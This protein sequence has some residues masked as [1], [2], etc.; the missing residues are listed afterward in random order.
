M[1]PSILLAIIC[2]WIT[3][4]AQHGTPYDPANDPGEATSPWSPP[5]YPG[6]DLTSPRPMP[7]NGYPTTS[8]GY[9]RFE[10]IVES[11]VERSMSF[12]GATLVDDNLVVLFERSPSQNIYFWEVYSLTSNSKFEVICSI[13]RPLASSG[14]FMNMT[15]AGDLVYILNSDY[16]SGTNVYQLDL[17]DCSTSFLQNLSSATS[18]VR[19]PFGI[20][21]SKYYVTISGQL[22]TFDF[23][24]RLIQPFHYAKESL[25]SVKPN[26]T[27][28]SFTVSETGALWY[29]DSIA[30]LWQGRTDGSW[31]GWV[32]LPYS[33]Y[34]DLMNTQSLVSNRDGRLSIITFDPTATERI[35]RVY[36]IDASNF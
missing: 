17:S 28:P 31:D 21:G 26:P 33:T 18:Y 36:K 23:K 27:Y 29:T 12:V 9:V 34:R 2:I 24:T 16:R 20:Q 35:L 8:G 7:A 32:Q 15:S 10:N 4:C 11:K 1:K 14:S 22:Q 19:T 5:S 3:G 25:A 13:P 30:R 6:G